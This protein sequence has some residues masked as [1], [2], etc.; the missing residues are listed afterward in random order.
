M[1]SALVAAR[2]PTHLSAHAVS[3]TVPAQSWGGSARWPVGGALTDGERELDVNVDF[4]GRIAEAG[5][6]AAPVGAA[7][8]L[9]RAPLA[10]M[11]RGA[12]T[13]QTTPTIG[14]MDVMQD[15]LYRVFA[16]ESSARMTAAIRVM[17]PFVPVPM[18]VTK[19]SIRL[20]IMDTPLF[21]RAAAFTGPRGFGFT[22]K[23]FSV[24]V[25]TWHLGFDAELAMSHT[26]FGIELSRMQMRQLVAAHWR[27]VTHRLA[28][29]AINQHLVLLDY[30]AGRESASHVTQAMNIFQLTFIMN[31]QPS[32]LQTILSTVQRYYAAQTGTNDASPTWCLAPAGVIATAYQRLGTYQ[33]D[34]GGFQFLTRQNDVDKMATAFLF[35]NPE[36]MPMLAGTSTMLFTLQRQTYSPGTDMSI[37]M[38]SR[39]LTG[40]MPVSE[41]YHWQRM[42]EF[43]DPANQSKPGRAMLEL[44]NRDAFRNV[45]FSLAQVTREYLDMLSEGTTNAARQALQGHLG[46]SANTYQN[47]DKRCKAL[48]EFVEERVRASGEPDANAFVTAKLAPGEASAVKPSAVQPAADLSAN[49][50]IAAVAPLNSEPLRMA[51]L[52]SHLLVLGHRNPDAYMRVITGIVQAELQSADGMVGTA[53][54]RL[55]V[56][57]TLFGLALEGLALFP[58]VPTLLRPFITFECQSLV[59]GRTGSAFED[60]SMITVTGPTLLTYGINAH[61]QS[62]L[63]HCKTWWDVV[64]LANGLIVVC[65]AVFASSY[66]G[67]ADTTFLLPNNTVRSS[68]RVHQADKY[69]DGSLM[70]VPTPAAVAYGMAMGVSPAPTTDPQVWMRL[71]RPRTVQTLNPLAPYLRAMLA[72]HPFASSDSLTPA[73]MTTRQAYAPALH[74]GWSRQCDPSGRYH[75]T[76]CNSPLGRYSQSTCYDFE[77]GLGTPSFN[78]SEVQSVRVM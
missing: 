67:G 30:W 59:F 11:Y 4:L 57:K 76:A 9:N 28:E 34:R 29:V 55:P 58:F 71:G 47:A 56:T 60:T 32:A 14:S 7:D 62:R 3:N 15:D 10:E 38:E 25:Q 68:S 24:E 12:N 72:P 19:L 53:Q 70:I 50:I 27:T 33:F 26:P 64:P 75:E 61:S 5:A 63:V 37:V 66:M 78:G 77:N 65:P 8:L 49:A 74:D 6:P 22:T 73:H 42:V 43:L 2:A 23:G 40:N 13:H 41:V 54:Q 17:A 44:F 16:Q 51:S 21:E 18:G 69:A 1:A 46:T 31:R 36:N 20:G 39:P 48:L 45:R 52:F 35:Q